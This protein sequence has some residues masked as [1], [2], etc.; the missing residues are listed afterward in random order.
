[1]RL[2]SYKQGVC[3]K[4][5]QVVPLTGAKCGNEDWENYEQGC[6]GDE[7][8]YKCVEHLLLVTPGLL[9]PDYFAVQT[10]AEWAECSGSLCRPTKLL[11]D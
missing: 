3:P 5:K 7:M 4:C 9:H 6:C 8:K 11:G 2:I 10:P 1:M